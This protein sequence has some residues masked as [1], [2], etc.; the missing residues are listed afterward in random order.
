METHYRY[1]KNHIFAALGEKMV[2]KVD[3]DC[4]DTNYL[5]V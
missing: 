2:H 4:T 3:Y 1:L 5:K